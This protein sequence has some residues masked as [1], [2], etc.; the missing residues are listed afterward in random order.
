[1]EIVDDVARFREDG[2]R[3]LIVLKFS[4]YSGFTDGAYATL[5]FMLQ[6]KL[7]Q[8]LYRRPVPADGHL[9]DIKLGEVP[10]EQY[11]ADSGTVLVVCDD[12]YPVDITATGIWAYR[13]YDSATANQG[14]LIVYDKYSNK[15]IY[16]KMKND[17]LEKFG[18]YDG[19]CAPPHHEVT[20]DQ[21]LLSWT[22]TPPT[23]V[24][25]VSKEANRH[26]GEVMAQTPR[27]NDKGFVI[28]YLY[29]DYEEY[30]RATDV[31]M[32]MNG[33]T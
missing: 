5:V 25:Q 6:E 21:F 12:G 3:E 24:W 17:Q 14:N 27:H 26:L 31:A 20:C 8:W 19:L 16:D 2:K 7:G 22:L 28:N 1:S 18:A 15:L 30:S 32:F 9:W 33:I 13:D 29:V 11:L 10:L 23:G 4:H